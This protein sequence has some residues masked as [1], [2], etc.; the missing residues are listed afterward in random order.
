MT[1]SDWKVYEKAMKSARSKAKEMP[2]KTKQS[3][4]PS[5]LYKKLIGS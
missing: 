4:R 1:P 5:G 2:K 3:T